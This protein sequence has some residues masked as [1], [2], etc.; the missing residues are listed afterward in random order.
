MCLS[1]QCIIFCK[2]TIYDQDRARY[3]QLG[4]VTRGASFAETGAASGLCRNLKRRLGLS[5][6]TRLHFVAR[7]FITFRLSD[8]A[9][10]F[11]KAV[12]KSMS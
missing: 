9:G 10:I 12:L 3:F 2:Q 7:H 8:L 11:R 6:K 1:K 4:R 5:S